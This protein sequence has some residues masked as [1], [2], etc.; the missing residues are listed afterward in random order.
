MSDRPS[1]E[2]AL[3]KRDSVLRAFVAADGRIA[4]IPVKMAKRLVVLDHVAQ[5]FEVGRH[6]PEREVDEVLRRFHDD[7]AALRR[8]LVDDGFLERANGVYWRSGGTV[9]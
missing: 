1:L 2:Q 8:Y 4:Q 5:A 7:W 9:T 6:Y 3:S